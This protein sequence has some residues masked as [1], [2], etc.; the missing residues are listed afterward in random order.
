MALEGGA[1]LSRAHIPDL[2]RVVMA[3]G[4]DG[5]AV[6]AERHAADRARVAGQGSADLPR[7]QVPDLDR[8]VAVARDECLAVAAEGQRADDRLPMAQEYGAFLMRA[9]VPDL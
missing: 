6:A 1:L 8:A 7:A 2:E 4:N 3:A 5:L 9:Q